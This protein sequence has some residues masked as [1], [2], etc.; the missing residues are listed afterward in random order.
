MSEILL[1]G[2]TIG[3]F[4][5]GQLGRMFALAAR[6]LGYR[7]NVF[8]PDADSPTGQLAD[9]EIVADY[10]DLEAVRRFAD[11]VDVITYEFEN[12]PESTVRAAMGLK[13]VRPGILPLSTAKNRIRE[14]SFMRDN[15]FPVTPF[16]PV[17]SLDDLEEGVRT[18]GLPAVLKTASWGYDG[19]GQLKLDSADDLSAAWNRMDGAES[20]LESWISFEREVSV[21]ATRCMHGDFASFGVIE[22]HHVNHIL[23]V[24]IAPAG[25]T[26]QAQVSADE[27]TRGIFEKL[28]VVGTMAVEYF[29]TAEGELMVNEIAPR[30][31]NSGHLTLGGCETDQF[32]QQLRAVCGLPLGSVRYHRCAAMANLLGDLW[33]NGEPDWPAACAIPGVSLHLYGKAEPRTGRKMGHLTALADTVEEARELALYA[34]ETVIGEMK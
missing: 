28:D 14:K 15:G 30:P 7:L 1:P 32:E 31:H 27:I 23:D 3:M 26:P 21:V 34:R 9:H 12:I 20:I 5:S 24:S 2:S 19:K 4:G 13:P 33:E 18:L 25:V 22:N 29:L 11:G 10:H 16:Y 17:N 8:S 6:R